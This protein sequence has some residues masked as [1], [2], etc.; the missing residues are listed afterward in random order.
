[1]DIISN[2][3]AFI[4]SID[5]DD[6]TISVT[7]CGD[8]TTIEFEHYEHPSIKKHQVS[9]EGI[10]YE[11][12]KIKENVE[13]ENAGFKPVISA[14]EGRKKKPPLTEE[15]K[16]NVRRGMDASR[17]KVKA[18]NA[19]KRAIR[20][21]KQE[22]EKRLKKEQGRKPRRLLTEEEKEDRRSKLKTGEYRKKREP[23]TEEQKMNI[24]VGV[25]ER[26]DT[27]GKKL[28]NK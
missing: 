8:V 19:L 24:S 13:R 22:K 26:F 25:K 7:T 3:N 20:I 17:E 16:E 27:F 12:R 28:K 14:S 6:P 2:L 10:T 1:M 9:A 5:V 11:L 23:L 21:A 18:K 4:D 15:Q